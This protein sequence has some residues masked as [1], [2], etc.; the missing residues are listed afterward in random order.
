MSDNTIP[1][2]SPAQAGIVVNCL[3]FDESAQRAVACAD[4]MFTSGKDVVF[5]TTDPYGQLWAFLEVGADDRKPLILPYAG[6]WTIDPNTGKFPTHYFFAPLTVDI[7]EG[8]TPITVN[9]IGDNK[10][11]DAQL[12]LYVENVFLA[13]KSIFMAELKRYAPA[14]PSEADIQ[15]ATDVSSHL[16]NNALAFIKSYNCESINVGDLE[17]TCGE[18]FA[19]AGEN[20]TKLRDNIP[21]SQCYTRYANDPPRLNTCICCAPCIK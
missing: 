1:E 15:K 20:E 13:G 18:L 19:Q 11:N 9:V 12:E 10:A 3:L 17:R 6:S 2:T 16:V 21:C 5:G 4:V 14:I 8:G 7:P